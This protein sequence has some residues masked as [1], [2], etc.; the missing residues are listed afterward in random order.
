VVAL[1][2][3]D[4]VVWNRPIATFRAPFGALSPGERARGA[5]QRIED[6]PLDALDDE[7]VLHD[8]TTPDGLHGLL[9]VTGVTTLFG[10]LDAD[11]DPSSGETLALAGERAKRELLEVF[12]AR[13]E[14][15][16]PA[17]IARAIVVAVVSILVVTA[18]CFADIGLRRRAGRAL[19]RV[20]PELTGR[21]LGFDVRALM[22]A[23]LRLLLD[24]SAWAIRLLVAYIGLSVVLR[25]LPYTRPW[26]DRLGAFLRDLLSDLGASTVRSLPGLLVAILIFA[27]A[28][29]IVRSLDGLFARVENGTLSV[30]W[31]HADTV[32]ATRRIVRVVIF[33]FALSI[34]YPYLPGSNTAAFKG[35]SVFAGAM[36][37]LGS[38][39]LVTQLMSGLVII[40][41]RALKPGDLVHIGETMGFVTEVGILST[42]LQTPRGERIT[43]PNAVV[44]GN[45]MTNYVDDALLPAK[46]TI[47][48]NVPW[49][50]VH[51][52][53]LLAAERTA[54]LRPEPKPYVV[55]RALSD[56]YV[57][58]ELRARLERFE[59]RLPVLSALHS[60]I[61]DVFH[62]AGIQIMV[63]HF[64]HQP[65]QP[66][67]APREGWGDRVQ[68]VGAATP[69]TKEAGS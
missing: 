25:Q 63:P 2:P 39:G 57:E 23:A 4:L 10:L 29:L 38:S 28:R 67:V 55:Q 60:A 11:V 50:R 68:T 62:E 59:Q 69:P 42:K 32:R 18:L 31:L 1:A 27:V 36:L 56:F 64:E 41:S 9:V 17:T 3:A 26:G 54:G 52:L 49:R 12:A 37:T 45:Q 7:I 24:T 44:I 51:D 66:L 34:A 20:T 5:Q 65:E 22:L 21:A 30:S 46:V 16:R 53:L 47:G 13:L 40:Y 6:L 48:Y 15:R 19:A 58:Y 43:I 14:Q 33:L 8:T 61:Q 35:I